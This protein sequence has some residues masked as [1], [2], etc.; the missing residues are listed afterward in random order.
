MEEAI[1]VTA[2]RGESEKKKDFRKV[3]TFSE[4]KNGGKQLATTKTINK[5][6]PKSAKYVK[7]LPYVNTKKKALLLKRVAKLN[8]A[9]NKKNWS[10]P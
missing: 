5:G 8:R 1:G 2:I 6:A 3:F 4:A 10:F 9:L 7:A